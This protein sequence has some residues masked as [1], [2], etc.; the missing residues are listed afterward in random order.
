MLQ[1]SPLQR[2][3]PMLQTSPML[4]ASPMLQPWSPS[5][6]LASSPRR[7][8]TSA[9][10]FRGSPRRRFWRRHQQRELQR[11]C[12]RQ[13]SWGKTLSGIVP[14]TPPRG[15]DLE[16]KKSTVLDGLLLGPPTLPSPCH[17]ASGAT[18]WAASGASQGQTDNSGCRAWGPDSR[19]ARRQSASESRQGPNRVGSDASLSIRR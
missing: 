3:S 5:L 13:A 19:T 10:P 17:R 9:R 12:R 7:S 8:S 6:R 18:G 16:R 2:A 4:W 14:E 15:P 11:G 1:T